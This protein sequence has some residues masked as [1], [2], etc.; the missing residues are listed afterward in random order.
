M[1]RIER[2]QVTVDVIT[3]DGLTAARAV[4]VTEDTTRAGLGDASPGGTDAGAAELRDDLAIGRALVDLGSQL[5][6]E[7]RHRA[8]PA[9]REP[10]STPV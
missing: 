7:A 10:A 9:D 3:H 2:R 4:L 5:L 8:E 6:R 1:M